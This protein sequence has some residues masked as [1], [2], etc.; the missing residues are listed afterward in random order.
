M[1]ETTSGVPAIA[2]NSMGEASVLGCSTSSDMS[3]LLLRLASEIQSSAAY[4][5][6]WTLTEA[7]ERSHR[8][9]TSIVGSALPPTVGIHGITAANV[10]TGGDFACRALLW[11]ACSC[12]KS[13]SGPDAH[14]M[15]R[16]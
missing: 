1:R 8:A 6:R 2:T 13:R 5:P 10:S 14:A 15:L 12:A 9:T 11:L 16:R 4:W 7:C 3:E